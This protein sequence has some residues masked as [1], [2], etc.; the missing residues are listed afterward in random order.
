MKQIIL[1]IKVNKILS[2]FKCPATATLYLPFT[3]TIFCV[4]FL[5][6]RACAANH[7]VRDRKR[8]PLWLCASVGFVSPCPAARFLLSLKYEP[9][10]CITH[11]IYV[12]TVQRC[13]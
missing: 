2:I 3:I 11:E 5:G 8:D 4:F 9:F 6:S 1:G 10:K 7:Y 12:H 13:V